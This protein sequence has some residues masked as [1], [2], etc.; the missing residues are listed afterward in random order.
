MDHNTSK[1]C[2]LN[3]KILSIKG[4]VSRDFEFEVFFN[5]N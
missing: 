1:R 2:C 5:M 4:T 3:R